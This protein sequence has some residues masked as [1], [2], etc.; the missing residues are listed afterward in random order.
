MA[1]LLNLKAAFACLTVLCFVGTS[2][3][4][5]GA[6]NQATSNLQLSAGSKE[7]YSAS[8]LSAMLAALSIQSALADY[9]GDETASLLAQTSGGA[10][11]I[12][13]LLECDDP[14]T[15][16]GCESVVFLT[17]AS[18]AG[19]AYSDL[20]DFNSTSLVTR[21]INVPDQN[22]VMF[23]RQMFFPGGV[24]KENVELILALF[25]LDMNEFFKAQLS[26]VENVSMQQSP[27]GAGKLDNYSGPT[28]SEAFGMPAAFKFDDLTK[29]AVFNSWYVD[30]LSEE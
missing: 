29:T 6:P 14:A 13:T 15:G 5:L 4:A 27:S 2:T 22:L 11:F 26:G 23:G 25:L 10:R 30:F 9:E 28:I 16:T 1:N 17:G 21:V 3:T 7:K 24:G 12:V 20:N 18:N 19:L 8:D